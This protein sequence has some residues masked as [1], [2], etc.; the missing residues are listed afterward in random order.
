M[1]RAVIF[2]FDGTIID[3]EQH[4]FNVINKHLDN[5]NV[6]PVSIDFYRASIGGSATDLHDYLI[7]AIGSENKEKIYEEH[8]RTSKLLPMIDT[9]KSLM[10]FLKQRH[11]PM[12]IATSSVKAEI[13]PTF[14]ALGL[15]DYIDVVVGREDVELVKP[16]PELYL[17]AVQQLNYMPTQ[18]LAIEDSVNGATAAITAGLDV[19]VNTNEMTSA[20]DF[21]TVEYVAKDLN[22]D[23]IVARFFSK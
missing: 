22:Y 20:Q 2:D 3:T 1:Y 21:T 5:Y 10:A 4:L 15:D 23:Q 16:D 13:M 14:K 19:I 17:T 11:I 8:H 18:C 7:K 12:A 6:D 9:I